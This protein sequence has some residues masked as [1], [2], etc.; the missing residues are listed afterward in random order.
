[1]QQG[2]IVVTEERAKQLAQPKQRGSTS[3]ANAPASGDGAQKI[4]TRPDGERKIR[5]VGPEFYPVR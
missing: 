3:A 5:I 4:V 1:V 2:D